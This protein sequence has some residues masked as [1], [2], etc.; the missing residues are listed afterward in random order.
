MDPEK[1]KSESSSPTNMHKHSSKPLLRHQEHN[2]TNPKVD[3]TNVTITKVTNEASSSSDGENHR[4]KNSA[5]K[6]STPSHVKV[7]LGDSSHSHSHSHSH[8]QRPSNSTIRVSGFC[9]VRVFPFWTFL[10]RFSSFC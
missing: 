1:I 8:S 9:L 3:E 2:Y 5:F 10:L 7:E 4:M 6:M